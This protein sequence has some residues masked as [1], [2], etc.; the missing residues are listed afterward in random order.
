LFDGVFCYPVYSILVIPNVIIC[1]GESTVNVM[2][3]DLMTLHC[4]YDT[5][6]TPV[7]FMW[8]QNNISISYGEGNCSTSI[9]L[10][11][12]RITRSKSGSYICTVWNDVGVGSDVCVMT[13]YIYVKVSWRWVFITH[14]NALYL[15]LFCTIKTSICRAILVPALFFFIL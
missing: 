11:I 3:G 6:V 13:S 2:E 15:P 12:K 8:L 10:Q 14:Y 7:Q 1:D 9:P 5:N 4:F